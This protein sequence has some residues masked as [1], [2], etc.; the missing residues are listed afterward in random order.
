ML[1]S[2]GFAITAPWPDLKEVNDE[3]L[4]DEACRFCP[5]CLQEGV[6]VIG[7][8]GYDDQTPSEEKYFREQLILAKDSTCW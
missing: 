5:V 7:E 8:I 2:L 6:V 3:G 4:A 1:R